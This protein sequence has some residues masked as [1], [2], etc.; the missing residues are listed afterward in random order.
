MPVEILL[1]FLAASVL[2]SLAPGPDNLFVL[3]QG[4]LYGPRAG[5]Y[6]TL[7][8]CTGLIFHTTIAALGISSLFLLSSTAFLALKIAG[9]AY[10]LYLAYGAWRIGV[11]GDSRRDE[12]S[13]SG[14]QLYRRGI[15]MNV[16]N[17][18]VGIFFLAFLPQFAKPEFGP[19]GPQLLTLGA[20][21]IAQALV[22]FCLIALVAGRLAERFRR[23]N[24]AQ[25][26]LNRGCAVIFT[27]LALRLAFSA[28]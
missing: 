19:L 28:R 22:V 12:V 9:A 5:V 21:F 24:R 8:L 3:T 23:S 20:L 4:A 26:L 27:L 10:L 17:P 13:L 7:G 2:L 14:W 16:T 1:A 15:I 18:K 11:A 25:R 6:I